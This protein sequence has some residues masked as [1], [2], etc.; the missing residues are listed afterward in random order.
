MKSRARSEEAKQNRRD[1]ILASAQ[2]LFSEFGYQSTTIDMITESSNLSPAAFYIYF[3]GK[4]DVYRSL[5]ELGIKVLQDLFTSS[6]SL[7]GLSPWQKIEAIADSYYRFYMEYRELYEITAVLH[8]GQKDFFKNF[9]MVPMLE[10]KA[11]D[12]LH[13][14]ESILNEGVDKKVF[15]P[16]DT[17]N[18]SIAMWGTLDGIIMLDGKRSTAFTNTT[19][20]QLVNT[21]LDTI[22]NGIKA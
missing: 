3:E 14:I 17:W 5:N 16:I 8:L 20:K 10:E 19:L 9:N 18:T 6:L 4:T 21:M 1:S 13:I 12:I 15:R 7:P 22:L 2:R 11:L